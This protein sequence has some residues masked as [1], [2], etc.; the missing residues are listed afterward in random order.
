MRNETKNSTTIGWHVFI[1]ELAK[2]L[3]TDVT[4]KSKF[5]MLILIDK[6]WKFSSAN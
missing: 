5:Q 4:L 1:A 6:I 3:E 2:K